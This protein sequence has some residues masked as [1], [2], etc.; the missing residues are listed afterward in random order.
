MKLSIL[1]NASVG[2]QMSELE[3]RA[4]AGDPW[5]QAQ[6]TKQAMGFAN[7]IVEEVREGADMADRKD[8]LVINR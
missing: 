5:A 2:L 1:T 7:A 6:L 3:V 4:R 8:L